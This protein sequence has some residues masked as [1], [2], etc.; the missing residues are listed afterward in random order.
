[1]SFVSDLLGDLTGSNQAASAAQNASQTQA[2][3]SAAGIAENQR[4]FNKLVEL[5]SPYVQ[6]GQAALTAS[7]DLMGLGGKNQQSAALAALSGSP[8]FEALT[9]QGED[10]ILANASATGGLRGGNTERALAQFRPQLLS[11]LIDRQLSRLSG[12]TQLGQASA[13][14]QGAAGM[15]SAANI[16][17]LLG[18]QGAAV[19]GG[20]VAQGQ[21]AQSGFNNLLRAGAVIGGFF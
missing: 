15:N 10:A 17:N 6:A 20:Q 18:Q 21:A 12:I 4:Q 11:Q 13:A 14:G 19:A 2:A 3:S 5:L 9:R 16:A 8:E 1:M 7:G